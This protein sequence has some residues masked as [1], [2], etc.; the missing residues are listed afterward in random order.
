MNLKRT[1]LLLCA[2][3][4]AFAA[5]A[6]TIPSDPEIKVGK[7]DNGLTYY[8]CHNSNPAGCAEF[9]IAHNVG[10]LQEEENQNGLAHFL[11]HMAF[12]G[13]KHYPDKKLLEFL[14]EEG[15]RFGYNVNAYTAKTET[16]YNL[17]NVPL[18]RDSFIDSVLMVLHDWS[19]DISC[20]QQALDDERGVISEERRLGDDS[21][22]RMAEQQ[23]KL[24]YKGSKQ[25]ERNVIGT[26]EVINGFKR[27][28]I[29]VF[30]H[31]WYR[32][33]LQAI[34]VVGDFDV[35]SM[36]H[37]IRRLF[38]D[39]P[40][41]VNPEPKGS[42]IPPA[43][44]EPVFK[45]MT[46]KE[47]RYQAFKLIWRQ[48]NPYKD[49]S[50]ESYFKDELCRMI[51]TSVLQ[52]RF[53]ERTKDKTCPAQAATMV[54][55]A[56]R[57]DMYVSLA[58][59]TPRKKENLAECLQF[60]ER[61]IRRVLLYGISPAEFEV[62][63]LNVGDRLKLN[64]D[65]NREDLKNPEIVSMALSNFIN[66]TPLVLP[67]TFKEIRR[68]ILNSITFADVAPYPSI[69][70]ATSGRI[71]SNCYNNVDDAGIA[72]SLEQM[73]QVIAE[74]A[75]EDIAPEFLEYPKM[76]MSVTAA[77]G[78]ILSQKKVSGTDMELWKL[79]NGASVYYKQAAPVKRGYHLAMN[80]IFDTGYR[81]F[82]A[83]S[84]TPARYALSYAKRNTGF[85]G[86]GKSDQKNYPELSGIKLMLMGN[87]RDARLLVTS[88]NKDAENAFKAA[89]RQISDPYF[90]SERLLESSK[91]GSL[92]SLGKKKTPKDLF[93][94]RCEKELYGNHPWLQEL[95]SASVQAAS[96]ASV[97]DAY[98]RYYGD[99]PALKVVICSD[100]P[101]AEIQ[102]LVEKYIA[103]LNVDYPY[104]KGKYLPA[105]PVIRERLDIFE[106][107]TPLSEPLTQI[108]WNLY[109]NSDRSI[110][111]R[112][113]IEIL[114]Y[115]MSARYLDLIREK[116]GGAYRVQF[117]TA[118]A[119]E[120]GLPSHSR[121]NFQT[122]PEMRD[123]LLG[124]LQ[125]ELDCMCKS[126]PTEQEME[127][128]VKYLVKHYY[129]AQDQRACSVGL[130]LD[131]MEEF[132]RFG[133]PYG[134]DYEKAVRSIKPC[135]IRHLARKINAGRKAVL[136]YEEK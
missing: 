11:E 10:A 125:D 131:Q 42:Y 48:D 38:C 19:C 105:K 101:R 129:E 51:V 17:S 7:L 69:M 118:V 50:D 44:E 3:L 73:R 14:A 76:D 110:R 33:D 112:A 80:Y 124:D 59:L 77:P 79:S 52:D 16:V 127:H 55:T 119:S 20:E 46:D 72:P 23:T 45:D 70:F 135:H 29:L 134:Y 111:E 94:T 47:I 102:S 87:S 5:G 57:P 8:I 96:L 88:D 4:V 116:R 128:A 60:I 109:F 27:E 136:I 58:T 122:R 25:A 66:G 91:A 64:I 54:T 74:V 63:K 21:R 113:A 130:Q 114:D 106:T 13:T 133:T 100:A 61:E 40:A 103:S 41:A 6:Q 90:D 85:G 78:R 120:K 93:E 43:I 71:Y 84:I 99:I 83:D 97:E 49:R 32:P 1:P 86:V 107:T 132:V 75:A 115:I 121:V 68:G 62:A 26:L 15:V 35:D 2:L 24:I 34:I 95:D 31:K 108:S 56:Y 22:S 12:N 104:S 117:A 98:R 36:E 39:I 126:G 81:V 92:K 30:Y 37:R 65:L 28:E 123:L 18:V 67:G 89:Y 82:D 9:Y 53:K